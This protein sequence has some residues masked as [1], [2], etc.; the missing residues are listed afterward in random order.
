MWHS[1]LSKQDKEALRIIMGKTWYDATPGIV[2]KR[3][4]E[5]IRKHQALYAQINKSPD[6]IV[7]SLDSPDSVEKMH[8]TFTKIFGE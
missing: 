6:M 1:K 4:L 2:V 5:V 8:E 3:L 7:M